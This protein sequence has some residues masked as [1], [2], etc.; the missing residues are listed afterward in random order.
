MFHIL[1]VDDDPD[2]LSILSAV[3]ESAGHEV[4]ATPDPVAV[5]ELLREE[6]FD[7]VVLDV[8]MPCRSGW[9]VLEELRSDPRHQ[10]L[11]V[12]MLSAIG[13][14]PNRARGIRLGADDFLSKPF[15]PDEILARIEALMGR[16]SAELPDLQG[17]F[18][19]VPASKVLKALT[20]SRGSGL[21]EIATP[22]GGGCLSFQGGRC[23]AAELDGLRGEEAVVAL[24]RQR[25]GS[26]RL[27][28]EPWAEPLPEDEALPLSR[29]LLEAVWIE[30]ELQARRGLLPSEDRGLRATDGGASAQPEGPAQPMGLPEMPLGPILQLLH[31]RPSISLGEVVASR[32]AAPDRLRLAVAWMIESRLVAE[33]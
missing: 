23:M 6:R 5:E 26:F 7:A 17:E 22:G 11:P 24:L 27:R 15:H 1:V 12:L 21:L 3:F 9:E 16:R 33:A 10:R 32:L 29:L 30:D 4:R 25:H 18:A 13:D 2:I 31:D 19:E 8:M 14:P 20:N 28:L